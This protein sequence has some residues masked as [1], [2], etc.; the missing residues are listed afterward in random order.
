MVRT[1]RAAQRLLE[2]V[3]PWIE[4]A[5]SFEKNQRGLGKMFFK[6]LRLAWQMSLWADRAV[7][8][9]PMAW[10]DLPT[11]AHLLAS[12]TPGQMELGLSEEK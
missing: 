9:R 8:L 2:Q 4:P 5:Q 7:L 3:R 6:S 12:L 1:S 10:L 11:E